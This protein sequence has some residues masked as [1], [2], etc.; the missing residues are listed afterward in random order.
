MTKEYII[1]KDVPFLA[2]GG[3][4]LKGHL[5]LC[6]VG[7]SIFVAEGNSNRVGAAGRNAAKSKPGI[8]F[9]TRT[10]EGGVRIWRIK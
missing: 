9:T 5:C 10:V 1:E 8:K 2:K 6:E 4:G 7:D 3:D